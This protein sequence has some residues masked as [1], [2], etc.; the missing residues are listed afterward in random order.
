[1]RKTSDSGAIRQISEVAPFSAAAEALR[2]IKVAIDLHPTGGKVIGMVSALPGE[3]KT[4]VAAGFAAFIAKS[5]ARTLLIDADMRNPAMTRSLGYSN[6]P[7]LLNM[8]AEKSNFE[9]LVITDSKYKF[10]FLP[11]STRTKPSNS[12]DILNS[13]AMKNMLSVA[14]NDYDYVL[15]DLPPILPVVD[16]KAAAHLFDVFVLVV[17][18]G[19][20]STDEIVKAVNASPLLS[21]RLLGAVLNKTDEKVMRRFEGYSDRRYTYYTNETIPGETV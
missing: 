14:R 3:G 15:V 7:G 18:W 17:E 12:S 4:T 8:V 2:Y 13:P 5:G 16:V 1:V 6:A 21:E 19:S 20:T 9:D 11:S 10:D